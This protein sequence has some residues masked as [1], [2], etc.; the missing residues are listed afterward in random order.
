MDIGCLNKFGPVRGF[1]VFGNSWEPRLGEI[2]TAQQERT[3]LEDKFA[4]SVLSSSAVVVGHLPREVS[5]HL[6]WFLEL[7][8]VIQVNIFTE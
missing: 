6:W 7:G 5:R 1:H 8:G 3:N 2:L 4:V